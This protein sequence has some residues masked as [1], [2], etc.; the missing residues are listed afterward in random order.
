MIESGLG[1]S[2]TLLQAAAIA[3][4]A[5]EVLRILRFEHPRQTLAFLRVIDA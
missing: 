4:A 1:Q 5:G 2:P 3:T